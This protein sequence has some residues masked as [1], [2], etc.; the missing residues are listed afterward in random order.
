VRAFVI[1]GPGRAEVRDIEPPEPGPGQVVVAVER[2]GVCGTDVEFYT[3]H[4]VYLRT[5]EARYPVRIG[6]E[7]CGRVIRAGD[8]D[9]AAWVGQRVTGDTMLGC[10][11]CHRCRSGRQHLCADRFEIGIRGGWPGALAEQLLVPASALLPLPEGI[12]PT[13]GALVEPGGNALRV[14]RATQDRASQDRASQDW[15]GQRL[16][17]IGPGTI[18]LLA[19]LIARAQGADVHLLGQE[20][21]SLR[22]AR[23]LGFGQVWVRDTLPAGLFD[24]IIDASTGVGMPSL[25]TEL[26]E[27]GGRIGYIGLSAEPSLIDT[28]TLVLKDVT[29]SGVLSASGGLA[30]TIALYADGAVD[31]EPIVAATVGLADVATVLSGRRPPEWGDAPKVHIDP[32]AP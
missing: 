23:S 26:V 7:W 22:F 32:R 17:V 28:R 31:P 16:L 15:A 30:E 25:A 2:A 12:G 1:T 4:M 3:G 11:H 8:E 9:S 10:G 21:R 13:A 14:V 24:A 19:A 20:E 5:G 27:P 6:H 18:G 29:A